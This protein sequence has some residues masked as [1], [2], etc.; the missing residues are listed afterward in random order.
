MQ[1]LVFADDVGGPRPGLERAHAVDAPAGH[2]VFG[3]GVGRPGGEQ[4]VVISQ[5]TIGDHVAF[6]FAA[7]REF[8][9]AHAF[10]SQITLEA[11]Q[12]D[13]IDQTRTLVGQAQCRFRQTRLLQRDH[14]FAGDFRF[15]ASADEG[16]IVFEQGVI[17]LAGT[18][19][20][21]AQCQTA[22]RIIRLGG[23]QRFGASYG[24]IG[25]AGVS[26]S[27]GQ[28]QL[29]VGVVWLQGQGLVVD[30]SRLI[31]TFKV[32]I[33]ASSGRQRL[34]RQHAAA[35]LGFIDLHHFGVEP[36]PTGNLQ[37][38]ADLSGGRLA[39]GYLTQHRQRRRGLPGTGVAHHL[40]IGCIGKRECRPK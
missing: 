2:V 28:A 11:T 39:R 33:G 40:V 27:Q 7:G 15:V 4:F 26:L 5:G 9:E 35:A 23:H 36:G 1:P 14:V 18:A 3:A 19:K 30:L 10:G 34:N 29:Q 22:R 24:L 37:V 21:V 8:S 31:P 25:F 17:L 13:R 20:R 12:G 16:L 32:A 6:F 38:I